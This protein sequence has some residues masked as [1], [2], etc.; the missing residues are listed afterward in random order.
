M[1]IIYNIL[2]AFTPFWESIWYKVV[3]LSACTVTIITIILHYSIN[4]ISW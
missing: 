1:I 2:S 3:F 4:N